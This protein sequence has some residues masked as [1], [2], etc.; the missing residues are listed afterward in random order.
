MEA[1]LS[2]SIEITLNHHENILISAA[3]GYDALDQSNCSNLYEKISILLRQEFLSEEEV[4]GIIRVTFRDL[5]QGP[6]SVL[7]FTTLPVLFT[8]SLML[9]G[10][11]SITAARTTDTFQWVDTMQFLV[12][13]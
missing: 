8:S 1:F 5:F 6:K 3:I 7:L 12:S 9:C 11:L 13:E 4:L 2:R 10:F